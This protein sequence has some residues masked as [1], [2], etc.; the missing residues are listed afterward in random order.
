MELK[1]RACFLKQKI[2]PASLAKEMHPQGTPECNHSMYTSF[3]K[4][5]HS[6]NLIPTRS[7]LN[8]FDK[9][10]HPFMIKTLNKLGVEGTF[11]NIIKVLFDK[12]TPYSTTKA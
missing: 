3:M 9:A 8:V 11:L 10:Q 7:N 2:Q 4:S 5:H 1:N 12:P 6:Y